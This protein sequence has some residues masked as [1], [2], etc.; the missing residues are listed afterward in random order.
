MGAAI[1][2]ISDALQINQPEVRLI[3]RAMPIKPAGVKVCVSAQPTAEETTGRRRRKP[4]EVCAVSERTRRGA[5]CQEA[6][7]AACVAIPDGP[8]MGRARGICRRDCATVCRQPG[9]VAVATFERI[10]GGRNG[11]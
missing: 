8:G 1:S 9:K 4:R 3:G 2:Q 5:S 7:Y 6:C 10:V 11:E